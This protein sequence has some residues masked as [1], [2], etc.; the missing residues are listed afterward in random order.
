MVSWT[1]SRTHYLT[2]RCPSGGTQSGGLC[3]RNLAQEH[4]ASS[5]GVD[6][7]MELSIIIPAHN[8]EEN[9]VA[10]H[11]ELRDVLGRL[12]KT[13]EILFVD[14]G[15]TDRTFEALQNLQAS[16]PTVRVIKFRRNFGQTAALSAGFRHARGAVCIT[17]DAD[18]QND[19]ADIP[20]LLDALR[21]G[22]DC[23]SGW[24]K[25][26]EDPLSKRVI[27]RG[28]NL[29]RM[30]LVHDAI[31]DSGCTLKAY[32]REAVEHLDLYGEMHRFIPALSQ[33]RGFRVG[34][35]VVRHRPRRRGRTHYRFSRVLRG[36]MDMLIVT[37]WLRYGTRPA[38]LIGGAGLLA[39][40]V[41]VLIAAWL[42]VQ[43][44]AYGVPLAGRP[45][46]LFAVLLIIFGTQFVMFGVLADIMM[47]IY[48]GSR[49]ESP[50]VIEKI[51]G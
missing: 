35:I 24:R 5:N 42:S 22:F 20:R 3:L 13:H 25:K 48:Y 17:L 14:D 15:S 7:S 29:L 43:K 28:A 41:G 12:G 46:L 44:I 27:S 30:L 11:R 31:H 23:V 4:R 8:E 18:L 38:H 19:P 21:G 36:F 45:L 34:E 1:V 33:A 26:R 47:K 6:Y 37:F 9:V 50:Y 32:K 16:D 39:F 51:I 40:G 2:A 49:E 10:L